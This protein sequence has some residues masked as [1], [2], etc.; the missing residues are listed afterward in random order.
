ME[1]L[2]VGAELFHAG[3]RRDRQMDRHD[4]VNSRN[5]ANAP[6]NDICSICY[7]ILKILVILERKPLE[8]LETT[9]IRE[10]KQS[11]RKIE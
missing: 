10:M 6:K 2:I 3:I 1:I 7:F 9:V 5:F 8:S 4:E 11:L